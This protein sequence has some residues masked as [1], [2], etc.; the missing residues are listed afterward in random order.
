MDNFQLSR[1]MKQYQVTRYTLRQALKNLA[2]LGYIYQAHGSGTFAR[3]HHVEGAISLQNN[4]GLTAEMARQGKIVRQP[5]LVNKLCHY[6]R[7]LLYLRARSWRKIAELISV[8]RQRTLDDEP[9]LVEHSYYLKSMVGEIPDSALKGS[10]FAFIDQKPGLK[11]GFIDSVIECEMITGT[12]AQFFNLADGSPSLVVRDD[13]YLSS[14]NYLRF[15]KYFM[16]FRKTK[17]FM[18][19]KM[20]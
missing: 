15:Q 11:V 19:K 1:V 16:I 2:N 8:I 10:L 3:P 18:L 20:H 6:Q 5:A 13:S 14:G 17:F 12:P 9:F 4:V 7:Q